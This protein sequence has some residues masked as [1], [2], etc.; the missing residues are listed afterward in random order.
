[1]EAANPRGPKVA[2]E[3]KKMRGRSKVSQRAADHATA[4]DR[5]QVAVATTN[6]S[7][8]EKH[9]ITFWWS[10]YGMK[11]GAVLMLLVYV[12]LHVYV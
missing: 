9:L 3:K 12:V 8:I 10:I 7:R 4:V 11:I 1:M 6:A 5:S 2:K